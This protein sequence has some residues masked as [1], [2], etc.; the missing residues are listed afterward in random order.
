MI[1]KDGFK[2]LFSDFPGIPTSMWEEK[3]ISDL[4]GADYNR[5]LV[6]KSEEGITVK[7]YYRLEDTETLE[8]LDGLGTLKMES[9]APNGWIICQDIF[10]IN[11]KAETNLRIKAAL[12][13][14]AQAICL[15]LK[16]T[17]VPG[18]ELLETL[19]KGVH[20][21]EF[22]L[23]VKSN[24][25]ADRLYDNLCGIAS[26]RGVEREELKGCLG[27]D[28]LGRMAELGMPIAG[29]KN[30]IR[31]VREVHEHSPDMRVIEVNGALIQ[32][33][34]ST[35]VEELA[36]SM[37]MASEY[38]SLLTGKGIDPLVAQDSMLL[39]LASGSNY[40]ME[41]AKLRAARILW[42]KIAEAYGIEPSLCRIRIHS[43]SSEWNMTLYDP[44]VN[45][46][47][48]TTE[49]MSSILGGADLVS[50]LPFDLP[51]GN[52]TPFSDRIAR[53]VQIILREEACFDRVADPAS[54]SY[55]LENLTDSIGE[56][57]WELFREVETRGGFRQA[58]E[59]GWIQEQVYRSRDKKIAP[60]TTGKDKILGTNAF[61]DFSEMI[62]KNIVVQKEQ[63]GAGSSLLPLQPFRAS[64][65]FEEVRLQTEKSNKRPR[66][67]LFKYGDPAWVSARSS[68][69]G[70]FFACAGY[71]IL[72]HPPFTTLE[73]GITAMKN[74]NFDVV[75]FC[76]SDDRYEEMVATLHATLKERSV[77]V[78]AGYPSG[79]I[80]NLTN[81]GIQH[82]I[83]IKSD[84]LETL[85]EFNNML[86]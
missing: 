36:L 75:V 13:G 72:D 42:S 9:G 50:V 55:L 23:L 63:T 59:A 18:P 74:L 5:K 60:I 27:A 10:S 29:M 78:V 44:H 30:I 12:K 31:L 85:R 43:S 35:L 41:I 54:G 22:E 79:S 66:V 56:K 1:N 26:S 52:S 4:K 33:A 62:L 32:N 77:V 21:G 82:F 51:Y 69:A 65:P 64:A 80:E 61:P 11:E 17:A 3:I 7:P 39:S 58:F 19:L 68:F 49:A 37:A 81:A 57:A 73:E 6:W 16:D 45:M 20:P 46:L 83:H 24:L 67:L 2:Q 14:G 84:L 70:N 25:A 48:G 38:M 76:S 47:R 86:L 71:E 28:P 53:N 8:Y 15:R 40:Y 34:G